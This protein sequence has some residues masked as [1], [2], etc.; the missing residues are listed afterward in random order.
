MPTAI[1]ES[2]VSSN[3]VDIA[4]RDHGGNGKAVVLLH[5]G[6]RTMLE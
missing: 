2:V 4:V 6:G 3:G 5:G 1:A